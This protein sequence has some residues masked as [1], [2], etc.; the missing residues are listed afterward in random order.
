VSGLHVFRCLLHAYPREF[1]ERFEPEMIALFEERRAAAG[2]RAI[3][4]ARFWAWVTIDVAR[5]AVRERWPDNILPARELAY[6]ARQAWRTIVRAPLLTI[7]VVVLMALAIGSTT[8][9]FSVVHAVLLRPFPFADPDRLVMIWERRGPESPRSNVG[10]HEYPEWKATARSFSQMAAIAFDRDYNLTGAGEPT[11]L[12]AARVT[13]EFFLVMG[14]APVVGRAFT[15]D[16]DQPGHGTVAIISEQLWRSRFA[17]DPAITARTIQLNGVAHAVVGVM[18]AAF[19]FP[20][21]PGGAAPEIWTPIAEPIH[22]Y[23][24]RHYLSVVARLKAGVTTAQAQSE[25]DGVAARIASDLPQFSRGHGVLVQPLHGALVQG[26]RRALLVVFTA[27]ALVLLIG[28]CNVANLL[29]ARAATRQQ[30]MALRLALGAGRARVA[31]QLLAEGGILAF[32]GGS[33]GVLLAAWLISLARSHD[34]GSPTRARGRARSRGAL[35][36]VRR[37]H[38]DGVGLRARSADTS[39]ARAGGGS[40]EARRER[41]CA[42]IA[43]AVASRPGDRGSCAHD[44]AGDRGRVVPAESSQSRARHAWICHAGNHVHGRCAARVALSNRGAAARV[45]R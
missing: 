11:K 9:V 21:G 32:L 34:R 10:A 19:S 24:G 45:L 28:C 41:Y 12:V 42:C 40:A 37:E 14:V 39:V 29:V 15:A 13:S 4:R 1:R 31:R 8:A 26:Y 3:D 20:E 25:L 43:S 2:S 16:E 33:A 5:S 17:A 18:P 7:F 23:R 27:V 22:L 30:E 6:D 44:G 38:D 36:R 35:L